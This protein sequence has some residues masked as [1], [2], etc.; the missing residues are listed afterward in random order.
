[1]S[2]PDLTFSK[3]AYDG[4]GMGVGFSVC[5]SSDKSTNYPYTTLS[6]TTASI[7][8]TNGAGHTYSVPIDA[9]LVE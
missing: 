3:Y 1:L 6:K 2:N 8:V 9:P 5:S 7:N 4:A